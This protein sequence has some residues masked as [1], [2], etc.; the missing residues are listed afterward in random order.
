MSTP[1]A[2]AAAA[3]RD[4]RAALLRANEERNKA[5]REQNANPSALLR[6]D[7]FGNTM[8]EVPL[9]TVAANVV[10]PA[11]EI[12]RWDLCGAQV[13]IAPN[14]G[15]TLVAN[16]QFKRAGI[17]IWGRV[18]TYDPADLP[19]LRI[20]LERTSD[21]QFLTTN[22]NGADYVEAPSLVGADGSQ[23]WPL[24]FPVRENDKWSVYAINGQPSGGT[25]PIQVFGAFGFK[26]DLG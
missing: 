3:S 25:D 13:N 10:Q 24:C 20:G 21:S 4:A 9:M 16:V 5:I 14:V 17:V 23:L 2:L 22:G 18:G 11:D 19:R 8:I 15:P 7:Q 6:A 1:R 26:W 12:I